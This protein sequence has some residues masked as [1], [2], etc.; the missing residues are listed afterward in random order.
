MSPA[1]AARILASIFLVAVLLMVAIGSNLVSIS[2]GAISLSGG[3]RTERGISAAAENAIQVSANPKIHLVVQFKRWLTPSE[4]SLFESRWNI[5]I[6]EAVPENAYVI[7]LPTSQALTILA[8]MKSVQPTRGGVVELQG[9]DKLSPNLGRPGGFKIPAHANRASERAAITVYF[10]SDVPEAEQLAIL[11]AN[12]AEGIE[13]GG[14]MVG[15]DDRWQTIMPKSWINNLLMY[16][17][18]RWVEAVPEPPVEDLASGSNQVGAREAAGLSGQAGGGKDVLIAQFELC[19]ARMN[20]PAL[21]GRVVFGTQ[22]GQLDPSDCTETYKNDLSQDTPRDGHPTLVAGIMAGAPVNGGSVLYGNIPRSEF[23][24]VAAEA[25][26]RA[27]RIGDTLAWLHFGYEEA[28]AEGATISQNSWGQTCVLYSISSPPFYGELSSLYDTVTSGRDFLGEPSS[29]SGRMLLTA[30]A[31]NDGD[32]KN[33]RSLWGS[34]RVANSAKNVLTVGNVNAQSASK[35]SNWAH[36]SSGRGPTADGRLAP[37]LSAPGIRFDNQNDP[38]GIRSSYPSADPLNQGTGPTPA[39]FKRDWGTSFSTPV[40]SG[41]AARVTERYSETCTAEPSPT[42]LRALLV[43]TAHDLKE[44]SDTLGNLGVADMSGSLCGLSAPTGN[45]A[46]I[47]ANP[48]GDGF[49]VLPGPVYEG[50]DYV[51]GYGLVQAEKAMEFT[52]NWH[53]LEDEI[54]GGSVEYSVNIGSSFVLEDNKL[55]VTLVWD[56]PPW[57]VNI[58]PGI[59]HGLLHND[60]DLELVDPSGRVH[61]PWVLDP[62]NPAQPARQHSRIP[63]LPITHKMRD[64]RNTIE[65][66]AIEN[67]DLG[68]WKIRV[69]AGNMIRPAQSFALVSSIISPQV[70]CEGLPSHVVQHPVDLPDSWLWCWLFLIA[71][72]ILILLIIELL[73]LIWGTYPSPQRRWHVVA[74]LLLLLVVAVLVYNGQIIALG[75]LLFMLMLLAWWQQY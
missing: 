44:A 6:L 55:R 38:H 19:Q 33:I 5:T 21:N 9:S 40:V 49:T 48:L 3:D 61:L 1:L 26:I 65:Q 39:P 45:F 56:D 50:P 54:S 73:R 4:Q 13:G 18:V 8:E 2:P 67:P 37:V 62:D 31:G 58:P 25:R 27:Y 29:Y 64:R 14:T 57:P 60:L 51:F 74:A 52:D 68:S 35:V 59:K 20:H 16:D 12:N 69:R 36:F 24:G 72:I 42:V 75:A 34:V 41:V 32:E 71:L 7:A 70:A 46:S 47:G 63:Y 11:D 17:Q 43:H 30:S 53:F 66:V 28:M 23:F 22:L 10:F 15:R